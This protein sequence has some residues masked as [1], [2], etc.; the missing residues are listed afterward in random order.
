[1][2]A[3]KEACEIQQIILITYYP[4]VVKKARLEN[5][6]LVSRDEE[7]FL[8]VMR[9]REREETRLLLKPKMGRD[10]MFVGPM[11]KAFV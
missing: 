11:R 2:E 5:I 4:E 10:Q 9:L 3:I 1:M 8:T 7:G 6:L